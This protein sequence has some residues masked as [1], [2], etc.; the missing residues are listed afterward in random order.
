MLEAPPPDVDYAH[1][2][3]CMPQR[4][5]V[6]AADA[7]AAAAALQGVTEQLRGQRGGTMWRSFKPKPSPRAA[8][9]S[10]VT[11]HALHKWSTALDVLQHEQAGDQRCKAHERRLA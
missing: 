5:S 7:A 2:P 8:D 9:R 6:A 11:R 1:A 10:A 4:A 3:A